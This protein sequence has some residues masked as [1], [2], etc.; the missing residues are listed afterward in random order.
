VDGAV[1]FSIP[2]AQLRPVLEQVW[3]MGG[4]VLSVNPLRR[5]LEQMF[6]ELTAEKGSQP[7]RERQ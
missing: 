1:R 5:S 2:N 4:E 3:N 6:L 7:A